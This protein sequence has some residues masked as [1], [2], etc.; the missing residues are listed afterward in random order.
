MSWEGRSC[1]NYATEEDGR[2]VIFHGENGTIK[3]IANGY[4]V[5][6]NSEKPQLIKEVKDTETPQSVNTIGPGASYDM[7]HIE[8]FL[9]C[10]REGKTPNADIEEGHKS[11]LL[12]HL[13][14]IACR[15]G[16]T[17]NC[18]PGNGHIIGDRHAEKLWGREYE[19]GWEPTV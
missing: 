19:D 2:G 6:D 12:G 11:V 17:I 5:Y 14:N 1:N 9:T 15:I 4:S 7:P 3:V 13:G 16:R 10:I 8:N 18:D